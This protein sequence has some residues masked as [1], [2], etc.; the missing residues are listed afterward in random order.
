[1]VSANRVDWEPKRRVIV[2]Y[3]PPP[4]IKWQWRLLALLAAFVAGL[5]LG[6]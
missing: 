5:M 4:P 2:L 1:M 6:R 3:E